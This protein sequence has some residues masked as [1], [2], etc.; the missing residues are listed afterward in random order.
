MGILLD[1]TLQV[2]RG[3]WGDPDLLGWAIT[4]AYLFAA[5]LCVRTALAARRV[6]PEYSSADR[7]GAW[8]VLAA[9][10]LLL[11][12]NKQLD[13]QIIVRELG[14]RFVG[15]IGL[16]ENRRWVGRAFVVLLAL[17]L[18][19]V[20][21]TAA[22]RVRG[23]TRGHGLLLTDLGL[24]ACFAVLRAG[25]YVPGLKQVNLTYKDAL[26]LVFELGG[27]VLVGLS[28]WRTRRRLLS[29]TSSTTAPA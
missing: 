9:G 14:L 15:F 2:W 19:R 24:L 10:L 17:F 6:P 26:H 29:G 21:V 23:H 25:M 11:G 28:A 18:L 12:L 1:S 4:V 3:D 8:W 16:G 7:P 22:R 27:I 20:M 13:L 5:A